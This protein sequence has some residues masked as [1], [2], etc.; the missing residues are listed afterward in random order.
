MSHAI[1]RFAVCLTLFLPAPLHAHCTCIG[2]YTKGFG[3]DLSKQLIAGKTGVYLNVKFAF[4]IVSVSK[5]GGLL[6]F[7]ISLY[8]EPQDSARAHPT[9]HN[10]YHSSWTRG[11]GRNSGGSTAKADVGAKE[12]RRQMCSSLCQRPTTGDLTVTECHIPIIGWKG[13]ASK[14]AGVVHERLI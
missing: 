13:G 2:K 7:E 3:Y 5:I 9:P 12:R 10:S 6:L 1:S 8:P 4:C 11:Q 14:I